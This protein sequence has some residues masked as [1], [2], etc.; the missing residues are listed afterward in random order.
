MI[1]I[2]TSA[3]PSLFLLGKEELEAM[4]K[5]PAVQSMSS[6]VGKSHGKKSQ[7]VKRLAVRV[8]FFTNCTLET[9]DGRQQAWPYLGATIIGEKLLVFWTCTSHTRDDF[10]RLQDAGYI[11]GQLHRAST[12]DKV[13]ISWRPTLESPKT[14]YVIRDFAWEEDNNRKGLL[15]IMASKCPSLPSGCHPR[16]AFLACWKV[17]KMTVGLFYQFKRQHSSYVGEIVHRVD[18]STVWVQWEPTWVYLKNIQQRDKVSKF[19][20]KHPDI[21]VRDCGN[22]YLLVRAVEKG[23]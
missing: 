22:S 10:E 23:L 15:E 11:G 7:L 20:D 19:Y 13:L 9:S 14:S 4:D 2:C 17:R 1:Y 18:D 21:L 6:L 3:H 12:S 8:P 16:I 5:R